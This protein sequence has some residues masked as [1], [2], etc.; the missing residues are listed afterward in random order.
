MLTTAVFLSGTR[1]RVSEDRYGRPFEC[2]LP[3]PLHPFVSRTVAAVR[4]DCRRQ[5]E[6][7]PVDRAER[8]PHVG[9]PG[10]PARQIVRCAVGETVL[11]VPVKHVEREGGGVRQSGRGGE[12]VVRRGA[13]RGRVRLGCAIGR[14]VYSW[15]SYLRSRSS[16]SS[17]MA[18]ARE[19]FDVPAA[20]EAGGTGGADLCMYV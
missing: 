13:L 1:A 19:V 8:R 2:T 17:I 15:R 11:A 14:S 7:G 6:V 4:T 3:S 10:R 18:K 16:D 9:R 12:M 5:R 20:R